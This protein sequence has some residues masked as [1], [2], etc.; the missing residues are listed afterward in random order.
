MSEEE[1]EISKQD[2]ELIKLLAQQVAPDKDEKKRW[3]K[4]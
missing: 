1:K 4:V 3:I 2:L